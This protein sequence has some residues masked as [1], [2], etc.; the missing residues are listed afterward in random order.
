MPL[1]RPQASKEQEE[2]IGKYTVVCEVQ[3]NFGQNCTKYFILWIQMNVWAIIFDKV[4][5]QQVFTK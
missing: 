4:Y 3:A 5:N 2:R 1:G